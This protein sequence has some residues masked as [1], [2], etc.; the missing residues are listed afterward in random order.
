MK[1]ITNEEFILNLKE[2]TEYI[3]SLDVYK[4]NRNKILFKDIRCGHEWYAI[5]SNILNGR[6][7]S[8][9]RGT[10]KKTHSTFKSELDK[11]FNGTIVAIDL[12]STMHTNMDFK[13]TLCDHKWTMTPNTILNSSSGCKKCRPQ[14][15]SHLIL[16]ETT[17]IKRIHE[18]HGSSVKMIGDYS[19]LDNTMTFYNNVCGHYFT[20]TPYRVS[21]RVYCSVCVTGKAKSHDTFINEVNE[22]NP[23][24]KVIGS[25]KKA[26]EKIE[27]GTYDC[28]HTWFA[29]PSNILRGQGCP[30]CA[31]LT[32]SKISLYIFDKLK[33]LLQMTL[34]YGVNNE[35]KIFYTKNKKYYYDCLIDDNII[36]EYHGKVFHAHPLIK[37]DGIF[38]SYEEMS[39]KDTHKRNVAIQ[40]GYTYIE[41]YEYD[42]NSRDEIVDTLFNY[43]TKKI[44]S[45][46]S[47]N[48]TYYS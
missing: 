46:I 25:Y 24:I 21:T 4:G 3:I 31:Y 18:K 40:N 6:G 27:F 37:Y 2:K 39:K 32:T 10:P 41:I 29:S 28:N 38:K 44:I 12:Y 47:I 11:K 7:C 19:G 35:L 17:I 14:K 30:K 48:G 20:S 45:K 36:I 8:I 1:K 5:P 22:K 15:T 26:K 9:C 34:T 33:S 42:F 23:T 13:C 16:N 43:F